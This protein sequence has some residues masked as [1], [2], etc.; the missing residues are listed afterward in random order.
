MPV[1]PAIREVETE[2]SLKVK[3]SRPA[4]ATQQDPASKERKKNILSCLERATYMC[5]AVLF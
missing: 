4:W 5:G 1:V 2:G 3:G